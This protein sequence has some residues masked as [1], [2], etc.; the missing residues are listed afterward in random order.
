MKYETQHKVL[1]EEKEN[2]EKELLGVG[3][4]D[5]KNDDYIATP[6]TLD[7]G[8]ISDGNQMASHFEEYN[9]RNAVSAIL[10]T[11]LENIQAALLRIENETYGKCQTCQNEIEE[12]RLLANPAASTC[13]AHRNDE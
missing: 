3:T 11:R 2:L 7:G 9:E 12:E 10:E 13:I 8:E 6:E 1:I 5:K 4:F